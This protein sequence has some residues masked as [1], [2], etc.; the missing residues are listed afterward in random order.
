MIKKNKENGTS[1][2]F[3][4]KNH[5][6]RHYIS[7]ATLSNRSFTNYLESKSS[8]FTCWNLFPSNKISSTWISVMW[9]SWHGTCLRIWKGMRR[10]QIF[11][12]SVSLRIRLEKQNHRIILQDFFSG[13]DLCSCGLSL[14]RQ[15]EVAV[16]LSDAGTWG[17]QGRQLGRENGREAGEAKTN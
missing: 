13:F 10:H 4:G 5:S 3:C 9:Q 14:S 17:Q 16:S 2:L 11:N 15:W 1:S 6:Q 7:M 12:P 8:L